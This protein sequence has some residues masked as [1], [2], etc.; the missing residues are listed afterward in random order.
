[1]L[2]SAYCIPANVALAL[3]QMSSTP[4]VLWLA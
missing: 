2:L 3:P 4:L 1:M